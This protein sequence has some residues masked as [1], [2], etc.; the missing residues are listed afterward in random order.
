MGITI[1]NTSKPQTSK[2]VSFICFNIANRMKSCLYLFMNISWVNIFSTIII[3]VANSI[4][5]SIK[6]ISK[7]QNTIGLCIGSLYLVGDILNKN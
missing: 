1:R 2:N 4:E 5:E 6:S 7:F 3:I